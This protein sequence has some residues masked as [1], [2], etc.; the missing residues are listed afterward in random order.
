[1]ISALYGAVIVLAALVIYRPDI[2]IL[3]PSFS[4]FD[5]EILFYRESVE[6][7]LSVG[8]DRGSGQG[9]KYT[10]VN[11]SAVIGSTYDAIK[12]VKGLRTSVAVLAWTLEVSTS[13]AYRI[14]GEI[15]RRGL[16]LQ[17]ERKGSGVVY[18]I[19]S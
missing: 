5:R 13:K 11:N 3:P 18:W 7:T 9:T 12:I 17:S 14:L 19:E 6:G 4:R 16:P 15:R 8:Q 2:K 1:M 10:F